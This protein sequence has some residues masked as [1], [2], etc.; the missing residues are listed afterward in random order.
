MLD[1]RQP[2]NPNLPVAGFYKRRLVKGGPW[3]GVKIWFGQPADPWTGELLD[4][5]PRWQSQVGTDDVKGEAETIDLWTWVAGHPIDEKEYR[6]LLRLTDWAVKNAPEAP[7]A[8]PRQPI[9][10]L[11][12]PLPF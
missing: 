9:N 2:I 3:T 8:N 7:E 6:Y 10:L 11:T 1:P 12:A 5:S 4:R